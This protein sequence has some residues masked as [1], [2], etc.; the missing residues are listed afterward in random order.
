M[1]IEQIIKA[2][3]DPE[4]RASLTEEQAADLPNHPSGSLLV[5]IDIEQLTA[6][7]GGHTCD[8]RACFSDA[9]SCGWFCTTTAEC[10]CKNHIYSC[11]C[12]TGAC[13][14]YG[15]CD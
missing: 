10:G 4:Y 6:V 8:T 2:W 14:C 9:N 15:A 1:N 13:L 5:E 11:D 12:S 7:N 3:K